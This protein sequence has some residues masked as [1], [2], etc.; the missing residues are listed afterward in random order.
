MFNVYSVGL[1][2]SR[3]PLQPVLNRSIVYYVCTEQAADNRDTASWICKGWP[4]LAGQLFALSSCCC[5]CC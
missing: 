1:S 2:V 3:G 5:C 4:W